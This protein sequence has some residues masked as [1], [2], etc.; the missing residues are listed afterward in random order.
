MMVMNQ[1]FTTASPYLVNYDYNDV[2]SG[3]GFKI[4]YGIVYETSG[5]IAYQ[6]NETNIEGK[7]AGGEAKVGGT[8][9]LNLS[10]FNKTKTIRGTAFI[11]MIYVASSGASSQKVMIYHVDGTTTTPT[12]ISGGG[13]TAGTISSS[14]DNPITFP[15]EL[16]TKKFKAGDYL[17]IVLSGGSYV[18][19]SLA[20]PCKF[21]IPFE[22][23]L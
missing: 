20:N 21:H 1:P 19:A 7:G 11:D 12:D 2:D 17:R 3:L 13:I 9:T 18:Y 15:V 22:L 16:T 8:A 6:L 23:N 14:I 5:G 4:F 10:P